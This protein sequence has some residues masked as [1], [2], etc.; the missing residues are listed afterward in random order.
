MDRKKEAGGKKGAGRISGVLR[1]PQIADVFDHFSIG[2]LMAAY[3]CMGAPYDTLLE[4]LERIC[5]DNSSAEAGEGEDSERAAFLLRQFEQLR[6]ALRQ[7]CGWEHAIPEEDARRIAESGRQLDGDTQAT[8]LADKYLFCN[9]NQRALRAV[10]LTLAD[11]YYLPFPATR[12]TK[13]KRQAVE[14]VYAEWNSKL[15]RTVFRLPGASARG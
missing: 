7:E 3:L 5:R 4:E 15:R 14:S 9:R 11:V 10:G 2:D 6:V 1:V 8:L 12:L 13:R